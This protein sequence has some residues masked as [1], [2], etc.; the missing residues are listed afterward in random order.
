MSYYIFIIRD[1]FQR[2][3]GVPTKTNYFKNRHLL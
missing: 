2:N 1:H 3:D